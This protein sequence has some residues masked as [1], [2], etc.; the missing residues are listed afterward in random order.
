[1]ERRNLITD[2]VLTD[3]ELRMSYQDK[4]LCEACGKDQATR[5][6][7][8]PN[9]SNEYILCSKC[10]KDLIVKHPFVMNWN[11]YEYGEDY[12]FIEEDNIIIEGTI[13]GK[14]HQQE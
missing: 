7:Q 13:E 2:R 5:F 1:M 12:E 4:G 6:I 3:Q 8:N 14:V 11:I 10:Y 9:N